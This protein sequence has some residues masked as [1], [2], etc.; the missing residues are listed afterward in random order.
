MKKLILLL[1]LVF[2]LFVFSQ[3]IDTFAQFNGEYEFKAFGNTLSTAENNGG[4]NPCILLPQSSANLFLGFGENVVAAF[5]YWGS[6]G[7]GD[8]DVMLN[9]TPVSADGIF[10]HTFNSQPYFAAR[11][12]V[13]NLI[14][15]TGSGTYTFSG[16]DIPQATLDQY[17][18]STNFGGWAIYVIYEN[19]GGLPAQIKIFDG[20]ESV[21]ASSPSLTITVDDI[22]VSS[23]Q[24][25]KIAFLAWE[26]DAPNPVGEDLE[27]RTALGSYF[28]TSP[29]NP[30]FNAFNSTN[31]WSTPPSTT[32]YQMD[33]DYYDLRG[34][35]IIDIGVTYIDVLL[36]TGQDYIM[37]NNIV[38]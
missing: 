22:E 37:V 30:R 32:N 26:G 20:L 9:G 8:F 2:P 29:I 4:G 11:A 38:T 28:P 6:V 7:T 23:S 10:S 33:L 3:N 31:S 13:T 5:L 35:G 34:A 25:S 12:D 16:M 15:T 36:S 21:S 27:L 17:C 18:G 19:P 14:T 1:L 24:I